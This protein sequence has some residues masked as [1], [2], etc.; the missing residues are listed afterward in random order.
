MVFMFIIWVV[1][2]LGFREGKWVFFVF[3]NILIELGKMVFRDSISSVFLDMI[4]ILSNDKIWMGVS[5]R[6]GFGG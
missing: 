5:V 1:V 4:S 6:L 3:R 2:F